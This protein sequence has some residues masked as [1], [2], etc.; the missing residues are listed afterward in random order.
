MWEESTGIYNLIRS[1]PLARPFQTRRRHKLPMAAIIRSH[2]NYQVVTCID[3]IHTYKY[4][5]TDQFPNNT[6]LLPLSEE[7]DASG[8]PLRD[9]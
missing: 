5:L 8:L 4:F 7:Q 1:P 2:S 3:D 6:I 9:R